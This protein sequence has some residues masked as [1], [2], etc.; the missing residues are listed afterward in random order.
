MK[1]RFITY[2]FTGT[3]NLVINNELSLV[4]QEDISSPK[5]ERDFSY[6]EITKNIYELEIPDKEEE[7]T[8]FIASQV[9]L[10]AVEKVITSIMHCCNEEH[11][12]EDLPAL[13]EELRFLVNQM[14]PL[15]NNRDEDLEGILEKAWIFTRE[16]LILKYDVYS[17]TKEE[18]KNEGP[19]IYPELTREF[20]DK[21]LKP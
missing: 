4:S 11:L 3:L 10:K 17:S 6:R 2:N 1:H 16:V 8:D 7:L 19:I 21:Y 13:R 15:T 20:E 5:L 9:L 12:N 18:L 14:L